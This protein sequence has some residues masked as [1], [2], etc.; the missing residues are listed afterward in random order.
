M[1]DEEEHPFYDIHIL[2][3]REQNYINRLLKKY[4]KEPVTDELKK[5]IWDELQREKHLGNI[6]IPFKVIM[7]RDPT[8]KFPEAIEVILDSKV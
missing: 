8:G 3:L 2:R 4:K 7:R 5:K 1:E 6:K